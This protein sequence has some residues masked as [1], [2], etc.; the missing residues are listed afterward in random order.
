VVLFTVISLIASAAGALSISQTV[1]SNRERE[2]MIDSL[3]PT[4]FHEAPMVNQREA[5]STV[6]GLD[7]GVVQVRPLA[8]GRLGF[9][10][11]LIATEASRLSG[12]CCTLAD[13]AS[14]SDAV[15]GLR[16]VC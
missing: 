11:L 15:T 16:G 10:I 5:W 8:D 9:R 12:D 13:P 6:D 4:Q 2:R 3:L 14:E 1:L 7:I